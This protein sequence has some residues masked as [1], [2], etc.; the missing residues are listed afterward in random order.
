[1][2]RVNH[3]ER[4]V[5][6]SADD[7]RVRAGQDLFAWRHGGLDL[8]QREIV[9]EPRHCR[10]FHVVLARHPARA[11][12]NEAG[13]STA[14]WQRGRSV[15]LRRVRLLSRGLTGVGSSEKSLNSLPRRL[16]RRCGG[17]GR[18][19]RAG[20]CALLLHDLVEAGEDALERLR[21]VGDSELE[22][23]LL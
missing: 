9:L 8:R 20:P 23:G 2:L 13:E 12:L 4:L 7:G 15:L 5:R 11:L 21:L 19:G 22:E 10:R 3:V 18:A 14:R 16:T 17:P 1:R 6:L